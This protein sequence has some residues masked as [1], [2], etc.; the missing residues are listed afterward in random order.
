MKKTIAMEK[1][2]PLA[3][4]KDRSSFQTVPIPVGKARSATLLQEMGLAEQEVVHIGEDVTVRYFT[5]KPAPHRVPV[6]QYQVVHM[7]EDVTVRYFA[8][9]DHDTRD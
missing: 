8:P 2:V 7:G 4:A 6:G 1:Q 5:P 3:R 9:V